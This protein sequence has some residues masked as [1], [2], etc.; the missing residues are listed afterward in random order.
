MGRETLSRHTYESAT[1]L[2]AP[3][4]TRVTKRAEQEAHSTGKLNPLVDPAEYGVIRRSLSRFDRVES[5][6][7]WELTVGIPMPVE[8]RVDTTGSM[9]HNVDIALK[10]LADAYELCSFVLPGFDLQIATGIF[11]DI[12]DQFVLCRPQFEMT[13]E[14]LVKQLTS[15][16]PEGAGGDEPEDPHYGL[17]GAAYLTDARINAYGLKGY[18]FTVSDAPARELLSERQLVRIFGPDVFNKV[19]ENGFQ[20][21]KSNLPST[22]EVF[23]DLLKRAHTFFLQVGNSSETNKFWVDIFGLDR[24]VVL[25]DTKLLPQVQAV[26]IGL[27]EGALGLSDASDFL[28]KNGVSQI[29][30]SNIMRSVSN[31][32]IGAQAVLRTKL[33]KPLPQK[34]DIFKEKT[35]LWPINPD[36]VATIAVDGESKPPRGPIWL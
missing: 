25:P 31:I 32:Q 4:P 10:V 20:L 17:F 2:H 21:N 12:Q 15:M 3:S 23:R 27:T 13:A 7:F 11:G 5:S 33:N 1:R 35:D 14:K 16:A 9:G 34:G 30:A 8:T 28:I 22:K 29:D 18:D 26:I 36:E 6:G 19:T 24:V